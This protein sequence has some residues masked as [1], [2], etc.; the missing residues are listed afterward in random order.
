MLK[1]DL[2]LSP[3][4]QVSNILV[5]GS[6]FTSVGGLAQTETPGGPASGQQSPLLPGAPRSSSCLPFQLPGVK[7][8]EECLQGAVSPPHLG[9]VSWA[10]RLSCD[11]SLLCDLCQ[12][13]VNPVP[14]LDLTA[15][16]FTLETVQLRPIPRTEAQRFS[17]CPGAKAPSC[18][19]PALPCPRPSDGA[20]EA[21]SRARGRREV[22]TSFSLS[23]HLSVCTR[24]GSE[25]AHRSAQAAA[26][27]NSL[28]SS[29]G[30]VG[31]L[32]R[33][34]RVIFGGVCSYVFVGYMCLEM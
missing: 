19:H 31:C 17:T 11:C 20:P 26:F 16:T 8:R 22:G 29:G 25:A 14:S 10:L 9:G 15:V 13:P 30:Q 33:G 32:P 23:V 21:G 24:R 12:G 3:K 28:S 5:C 34:W 2:G 6:E 18:G 4:C 1:A 27:R 7:G